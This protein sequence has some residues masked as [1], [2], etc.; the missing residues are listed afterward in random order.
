MLDGARCL[1]HESKY[2]MCL[3]LGATPVKASARIASRPPLRDS[4]CLKTGGMAVDNKCV[5]S[6]LFII[7]YSPF[8]PISLLISDNFF[9]L[10][11]LEGL[12][13]FGLFL[14]CC[15]PVWGWTVSPSFSFTVTSRDF[16]QAIKTYRQ[17][18]ADLLFPDRNKS[19]KTAY[20]L[21]TAK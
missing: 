13:Y 7:R 19:R 17:T 16:S 18:K 4:P 6:K 10:R 11:I 8:F 9:C 5:L 3:G 21:L 15:L 14:F 20:N 2:T 1:W 12:V